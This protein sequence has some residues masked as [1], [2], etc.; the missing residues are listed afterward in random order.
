MPI[1]NNRPPKWGKT[2][3][4][5]AALIGGLH[6]FSIA[7]GLGIGLVGGFVFAMLTYRFYGRNFRNTFDQLSDDMKAA[8]KGLTSE[9]L[10]SSQQELVSLADRELGKKTEQHSTELESKKELID[11]T[12][13]HM[14]QTLKTV[15]TELEKNQKNVSDVLDK[16][17]EQLKESNQNYLNQLTEKAATQSKAHNKELESKKEL[18]DQRLT[19]MDV[20]LGK[21]EQ[22]VQDLQTDRKAQYSALGQQLQSLTTTTASLQK[23]L[24]DNRERGRWGERIAE[25]ILRWMGLIEGVHYDKQLT[26][27]EGTRPDFTFHLPNHMILNMDVKFPLDNYERYHNADNETERQ[28]FSEKFLR[29]V[30]SRVAEIQKRDYINADTVDCV[31]VFIPNEQIYRF[32]HEQDHSIIDSAL[33]QKVILCSPLTLYIVLALI[34][35]AAQNFNVE[36]KSREIVSIVN[37]I[38]GEWGKY[39]EKMQQLENTFGTMQKRFHEL[40]FTRTRALDRRFGRVEGLLE[41]NDMSENAETEMPQLPDGPSKT[42][43]DL[44]F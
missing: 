25:D 36:R 19:D 18:I 23:A 26:T 38:R 8:F 31:L 39:T 20:K 12:L 1:L 6:G 15:P 22:L 33:R 27:G 29:D 43:D 16:S 32:I 17:A 44:P 4:D 21:V 13:E 3:D 7:L 14:S 34:R 41:S 10:A 28:D 5:F 30:N 24:A 40:T 9:A 11:T 37:E 2:M 35:Q 42:T